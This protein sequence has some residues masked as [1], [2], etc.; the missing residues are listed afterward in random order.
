[1]TRRE[2]IRSSAAAALGL[3]SQ[4]A[5]FQAGRQ[6]SKKKQ[7]ALPTLGEF[8]SYLDP[9]TENL[10]VRLTSPSYTSLMPPSSN[11]HVSS[12]SR[13]LVY[14]S[15][16][17]G[18]LSP[19]HLDLRTAVPKQLAEGDGYIASSLC[20]DWQEKRALFLSGKRLMRVTLDRQR[21]ETM[22]EGI[23]GFHVNAPGN[24]I[25]VLRQG[26]LQR[27]GVNAGPL[28]D[29][30]T[31]RG[32]VSPNGAWCSFERRE[33]ADDCS[34]WVVAMNGGKPTRLTTGLISS[35]CW[36]PDSQTVLFLKVSLEREAPVSE[37]REAPLD[38]SG[39]RLVL[40][41]NQ[42]AGFSPNSDGSV[43]VG[44]S[45]SKAQPHVI[46]TLRSA[47]RDMTLC[48]HHS[49]HPETVQPVFSPNSRRV[50]FESDR[51]GKPALY[52]VNVESLVEPTDGLPV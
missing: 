21:A 22:A 51:D 9:S 3:T 27:L 47:H 5:A 46:I 37:L 14:S 16:H 30:L 49:S 13:F 31:Q 11:R 29:H 40:S 8:F 32:L 6:D 25:V 35:V 12:E 48:E 17:G 34:L 33:A 39:E 38:G 28:A 41:T 43:F 4:A 24:E 2:L 52:A 23:D 26:R 42:F 18:S 7:K 1:M 50:Y 15:D 45:R 20:V 44:A 19:F 36:N 10:V